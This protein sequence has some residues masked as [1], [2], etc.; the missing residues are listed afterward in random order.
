MFLIHLKEPARLVI[1]WIGLHWSC[2]R[3][4]IVIS[5]GQSVR[6]V[7]RFTE[8]NIMKI[9]HYR[10]FCALGKRAPGSVWGACGN[11]EFLEASV[12][13]RHSV[14]LCLYVYVCIFTTEH[15]S[16][17]RTETRNKQ[18]FRSSHPQL[19]LWCPLCEWTRHE[20]MNEWMNN[21][22]RS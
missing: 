1:L 8:S 13:N 19:W 5:A 16:E 9:I 3:F 6:A 10:Y 11:M 4:S 14:R 22:F 21:L 12:Q 20:W 17:N 15:H 7:L 2:C 18:D